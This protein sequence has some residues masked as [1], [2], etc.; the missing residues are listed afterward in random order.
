MDARIELI[1]QVV[2][3]LA[4]VNKEVIETVEQVLYIQL[5]NYEIQERCT[6]V[7]VH[8]GSNLGL[9]RKFIATK[10]L[11]GKS[12]KTLRKYQPELEKL[13]EFLNKKLYE[14]DTYDLRLYLAL[15]KEKRNVSNRHLTRL[16]WS[17]VNQII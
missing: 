11:E 14:V 9:V 3:A 1:D 15:Y 4:G 16:K 2:Q 8:D 10:Q 7:T 13:V 12:E 5:Q 6:E 17:F